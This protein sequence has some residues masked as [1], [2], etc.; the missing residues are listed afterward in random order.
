MGRKSVEADE[1]SLAIA[2]VLN[3]A[4]EEGGVGFRE[5]EE[6]SGVQRLRIQRCFNGDRPFLVDD[7]EAIANALGLKASTVV[8]EAEDSLALSIVS[9]RPAT[10]DPRKLGLAAQEDYSDDESDQ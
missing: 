4:K 6:R 10:F 3:A 1:L 8:R 7:V 2:R 5:L 9:E